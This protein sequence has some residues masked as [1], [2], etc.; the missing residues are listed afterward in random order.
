MKIICNFHSYGRVPHLM[1]THSVSKAVY[2][3][4][5]LE[6]DKNCNTEYLILNT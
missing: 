4:Y 2:S 3:T 5:A 6:L 1:Q